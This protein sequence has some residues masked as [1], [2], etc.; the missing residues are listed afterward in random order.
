[1]PVAVVPLYSASSSVCLHGFRVYDFND[2][3]CLF[4]LYYS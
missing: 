3:H 4:S 2:S 1:M